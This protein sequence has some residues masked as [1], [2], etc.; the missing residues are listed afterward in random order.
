M[1][2][3][4][5]VKEKATL[6]QKGSEREE[7]AFAKGVEL[8]TAQG[9]GAPLKGAMQATQPLDPAGAPTAPA[10]VKAAASASQAVAR[11]AAV[12]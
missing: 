8:S 3:K 6:Q 9:R 10:P 11:S 5:V 7:G 12:A 4:K 1:P 2:P